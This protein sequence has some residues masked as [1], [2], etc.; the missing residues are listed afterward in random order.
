MVDGTPNLGEGERAE[1]AKPYANMDGD[2]NYA[3]VRVARLHRLVTATV[4]RRIGLY[5]GQELLLMQLWHEDHR[6]QSELLRAFDMD[7]ST[8]TKMVQRLE[9]AGFITRTPS[10]SDRRALIVSLTDAGRE[11]RPKIIGA[12]NELLQAVVGDLSA[13]QQREA[14]RLFS[15]MEISLLRAVTDDARA[16]ADTSDSMPSS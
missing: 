6:I 15:R 9:R 11:L 4:L 10:S 12:W 2:L 1:R 16:P 8:I 7:P 5:P 3:L 13:R 14:L